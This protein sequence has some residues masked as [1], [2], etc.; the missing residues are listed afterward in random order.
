MVMATEVFLKERRKTMAKIDFH[1]H[2]LPGVDD[3]ADCC[4]TSLD[5]L[6][7]LA[8][9]AVDTVVLTPHYYSHRE[10]LESFIERRDRAYAMLL[11]AEE[12]LP[13]K[14]MLGAEV[15]FSEYLF[16][17]SDLSAL[18]INRTKTMLLELPFDAKP[19][20][21][22]FLQLDRMINEYSLDIVLAH[23]ERYP[24]F[25]KSSQAMKTLAEIGCICQVNISS[26]Q[27]FG[28]RRLF[29]LVKNGY[30]GALGTDCHNLSSRPPTYNDGVELLQKHLSSE[31]VN[32]IMDTMSYLLQ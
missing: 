14:T 7:V 23:I 3:G 30:V 26:F 16:N 8:K 24:A 10:S 6:G 15:Y 4:R 5:M 32:E 17:S 9:Q 21:T 12:P 20:D 1:T 18:C 19:G 27:K 28:K 13:V 22:L 29:S 31:T 2:I 11:D 25:I